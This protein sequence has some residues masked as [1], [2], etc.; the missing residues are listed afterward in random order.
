MGQHISWFTTS[1]STNVLS[2]LGTLII[3]MQ[4]AY[5]ERIKC[6]INI[7]EKKTGNVSE[8]YL[9]RLNILKSKL[10]TLFN[11]KRSSSALVLSL[12]QSAAPVLSM[13]ISPD[14]P[15]TNVAGMAEDCNKDGGAF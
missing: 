2:C 5:A 13:T 15:I 8:C 7:L 12:F 11:N 6:T 1:S 14:L 10:Y 3:G 4:K 9:F